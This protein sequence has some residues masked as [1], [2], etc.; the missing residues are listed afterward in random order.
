MIKVYID[1][2]VVKAKT[3]DEHLEILVKTF[4]WMCL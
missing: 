2:V 1:N 3:H 4:E